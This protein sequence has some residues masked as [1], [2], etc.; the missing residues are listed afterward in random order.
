MCV[1]GSGMAD[2][3]M[4]EINAAIYPSVMSIYLGEKE[5]ATKDGFKIQQDFEPE[6]AL[7]LP[8]DA[9]LIYLQSAA[10]EKNTKEME[11]LEKYAY[12]VK[13]TD[14]EYYDLISLIMTPTTRNW[15]SVNLNGDILASFGLCM[16]TTENGKRRVNI[17][18]DAKETLRAEAWEG[19]ILD[20]L[21]E[22]AMTVISLFEF[23]NSFERKNANAMNKEELKIYLGAWKFSSDEA[24]QR[25]SNALRVAYMYTLVGYY[26]GDRKSQY[27]SFERYF[28]DE[29]YK[30]VSLMFGIW[31]SLEDKTQIEYVPLYDSFH[32][33]R[34]MSK[35][36]LVDILRAVLD[37]PD[38]DL[39][40]KMMLKNQLIV[41]VGVFHTNISVGDAPLEQS[42]IKPAVNFVMLRD[43]AKNTLEAAKTL[44]KSGLYVDCANRCYYAMMDALKSLLEFRGLLAQWKENEL[45]ETETHKSL[46]R[47]MNDLVSNGVL[48]A[49]D[50]TDF[51][52]VLNERMKCDY[53]LYVFK[54]AD[55][56]DCISRTEAFLNKIELLTV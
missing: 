15:T 5:D 49:D 7:N 36:D 55:A 22:S 50:A 1:G 46:E 16:E 6:I 32:N 41:S 56:L 37:N 47:A 21:R 20:I 33:L 26:C 10:N 40:D 39:D 48:S 18:E 14:A 53:S 52:F 12:G 35:K 2:K 19:I 23:A 24:E 43:K 4:I 11:L 13:F 25:L 42:L 28:E 3:K 34:G 30:R 31:T 17:I 27:S 45:K 44:E 29:Y 9:Y 54:Q 51:T 8:R 38:I